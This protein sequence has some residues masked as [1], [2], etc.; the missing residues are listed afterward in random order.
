MSRDWFVGQLNKNPRARAVTRARVARGTAIVPIRNRPTVK[1]VNR[2]VKRI[3]KR[4]EL[5]HIDNNYAVAMVSDPV[6]TNI[7]LLNG[8][9]QGTTNVGRIGDRVT[10][11]SIQMR[12]L[13]DANATVAGKTAWRMII[14]RDMQ[15]NG[16]A[17]T[18]TMLL[19]NSIIASYFNAPYNS[20][21]TERFRVIMDK[22]GIINQMIV[23]QG[24]SVKLKLKWKLNFI[25]N[26]GLGNTGLI[27]DITK[28]SVYAML[29]SDKNTA[30]GVGPVCTFGTRMY[31]KDD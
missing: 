2:K 22:R 14:F 25:T 12:G 31:F 8:V 4:E 23:A 6:G 18:V 1:S 26:Y 29:I 21:N 17:P 5:K 28:N 10:Y 11:T 9:G 19:D 24:P 16:T 13:I 30:S 27:G 3:E 15:S 20:D 7:L